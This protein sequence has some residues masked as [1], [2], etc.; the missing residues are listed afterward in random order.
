[1]SEYK[2]KDSIKVDIEE[3]HALEDGYAVR[4]WEELD[5][6]YAKAQAWDDFVATMDYNY[7]TY[8]DRKRWITWD[9]PNYVVR[10]FSAVIDRYEESEQE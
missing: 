2:Y 10:Q 8:E 5:E 9:N 7:P 3:T 4:A 1:M 6:V